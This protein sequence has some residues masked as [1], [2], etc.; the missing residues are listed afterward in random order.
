MVKRQWNNPNREHVFDNRYPDIN[1][2]YGQQHKDPFNQQRMPGY[3]PD[4][5]YTV[6][7]NKDPY[8]EQPLPPWAV[9]L[10]VS[11]AVAIVGAVTVTIILVIRC[12][13]KKYDQAPANEPVYR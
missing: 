5:R 7:L 2:G 11:G 8:S 1:Q 10:I 6:N 9:I 4:Y 13:T 12:N 3:N